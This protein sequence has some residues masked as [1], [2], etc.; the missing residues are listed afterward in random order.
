MTTVTPPDSHTHDQHTRRYYRFATPIAVLAF[1]VSCFSAGFTWWQATLI[2]ESNEIA[3]KNNVISQRAF[4]GI[5]LGQIQLA[6]A[7]DPL[8]VNFPAF[9]TNS[10]N[11][12]TKNLNFTFRCVPSAEELPEPWSL[13]GQNKEKVDHYPTF[14]T[15][16]GSIPTGCS[17]P[18]DQVQQ[19]ASKKMFGYLMAGV[20]YFD[21]LDA[22]TQHKTQMA[23]FMSQIAIKAPVKQTLNVSG[24]PQ[25]VTLN[26]NYEVETLF[27]ARGKHNCAD[28]ECPGD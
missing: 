19:M 1:V 10:G 18:W 22:G 28:E 15:G 4:V 13:F 16:H 25:E 8:G 5:T 11:T 24:S 20:T 9:L 26:P 2:G 7:T 17:F 12:P 6:R 23:L 3:R 14:I 27:E 21:R